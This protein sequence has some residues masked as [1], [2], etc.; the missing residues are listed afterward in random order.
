[1]I[2]MS[3]LQVDP[4]AAQIGLGGGVYLEKVEVEKVE[5]GE[6]GLGRPRVVSSLYVALPSGLLPVYACHLLLYIRTATAAGKREKKRNTRLAAC[7]RPL[8]LQTARP[9][10]PMHNTS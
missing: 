8:L 3:A 4:W 7:C 1:M 2:L 10:N 9:P 5:A 6:L